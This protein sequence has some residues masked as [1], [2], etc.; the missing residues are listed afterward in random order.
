[1]FVRGKG[2]NV[3][4]E[5]LAKSSCTLKKVPFR[6]AVGRTLALQQNFRIT[7][8]INA[9]LFSKFLHDAN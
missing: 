2:A 4:S 5:G 6:N 3:K 7:Y 9:E 8:S 1:M